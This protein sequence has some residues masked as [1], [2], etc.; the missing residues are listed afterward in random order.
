MEPNLHKSLDELPTNDEI[1][2]RSTVNIF[3]YSSAQAC[4]MCK[5]MGLRPYTHVTN[6]HDYEEE[7]RYKECENCDGKGFIKSRR[8]EVRVG[9]QKDSIWCQNIPC[10][11]EEAQKHYT[12]KNND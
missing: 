1:R 5:A 2:A 6:Y 8:K 4:P 3:E 11:Q 10:T 9:G 12:E 7:T